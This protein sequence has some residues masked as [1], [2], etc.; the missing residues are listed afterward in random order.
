MTMVPCPRPQEGCV[1]ITQAEKHHAV[2][3]AKCLQGWHFVPNCNA[4]V[5]NY[6]W[7]LDLRRL[8][9]PNTRIDDH[10]AIVRSETCA[11]R[12]CALHQPSYHQDRHRPVLGLPAQA[13]DKTCETTPPKTT[14]CFAASDIKEGRNAGKSQKKRRAKVNMFE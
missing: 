13:D 3:P 7:I 8:A 2:N 9:R 12:T 14:F 5:C 10:V 6:M 1:W 11:C 4:S